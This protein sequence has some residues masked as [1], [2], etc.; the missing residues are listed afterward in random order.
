M[1]EIFYAIEMNDDFFQG[2]RDFVKNKQ[3]NRG[4]NH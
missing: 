1:T 3:V 2:K 4:N